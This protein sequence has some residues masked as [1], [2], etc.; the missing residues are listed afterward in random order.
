MTPSP[1]GN[2]PVLGLVGGIGSGKSLVARLLAEH[3]ASV[4]SGDQLGHEA[5]RNPEIKASVVA[6]WGEAVLDESGDV[7]R[8]RL[9]RIVFADALERKALEALVFPYI[10]QGIIRDVAAAEADHGVKFIVLDAAIMLE[11]GWGEFCDK[12]VYVD[13]PR[14]ERLRRI[15][16]Q[17]GWTEEEFAAREAAQWP[18]EKK[19]AHADAVLD[20]SGDPEHAREQV[21]GVLS[22]LT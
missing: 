7:N 17:R 11:T 21:E 16:E 10:R 3:G 18:V 6:R 20:N 2:K 1:R 14:A 5:L 19:A 15:R 12:I 8:R 4:I 9:S 13:V 22:W